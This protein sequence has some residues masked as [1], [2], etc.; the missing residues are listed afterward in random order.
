[1]RKDRDKS[2]YDSKLFYAMVSI[3][4]ISS[5]FRYLIPTSKIT[6]SSSQACSHLRQCLFL[7]NE[8]LERPVVLAKKYRSDTRE[9]KITDRTDLVKTESQEVKMISN[10][11]NFLKEKLTIF[12]GMLKLR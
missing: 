3:K 1:M 12:E 10:L 6:T 2:C 11:E 5:N 4:V 9:I 8:V 7:L